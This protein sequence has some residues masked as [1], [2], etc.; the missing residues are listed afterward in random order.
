MNF[1]RK[2]LQKTYSWAHTKEDD[3]KL[4]GEPDSSLLNRSEGYEVIYMI[5]K[6]MTGWSL[7][8]TASGEKI[9]RMIHACPSNL[10][11]QDNV[12]TWI[13]TNWPKY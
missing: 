4:R 13:H 8:T 2:D 3:P 1:E 6:L 9:E 11:S 10:R 5:R 7:K 12:K